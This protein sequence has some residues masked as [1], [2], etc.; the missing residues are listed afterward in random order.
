MDTLRLFC[1]VATCRSFSEAARRHGISQSA[2][3]QRVGRLEARLGVTL[4]DRSVRPLALTDAGQEFTRGCREL[5]E[6][7]DV[8]EGRISGL[9]QRPAGEVRIDAIYSA[10]IDL[11]NQ[12]KEQF[13]AVMPGVTVVVEYK[14]PEEVYEA[15]RQQRCD[16]GILSYPKRWPDVG[17]IPLR[18]ERMVVVCAPDHPLAA[19]QRV[20][21]GQLSDWPMVSFEAGLPVGRR[22]RR[23]LREHGATPTITNVFDNIDTLKSVVAVTD[24]I[25][26]LPRRTVLREVAA[27]TLRVV[28]LDPQLDRTM[29][30]IYP[31]ARRHDGS[32]FSPAAQ[33]F[34]EFLLQHAG[35][36]VEQ[37]ETNAP[38]ERDD[39][40][41]VG[42][43]R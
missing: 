22:I 8:L 26:I 5:I 34:V 38:V 42:G 13:E 4:I 30:I 12:V 39:R 21:A 2:A 24:Q 32:P 31:R 10:G 41:L 37:V 1:D 14:R 40:Q 20:N 15:V 17:T 35:P 7:Y 43:R 29:G 16:L 25:S 19:R 27:G 9:R 3:S 18:N 6:R 36:E 11:L 23:Y 28:E 33:A